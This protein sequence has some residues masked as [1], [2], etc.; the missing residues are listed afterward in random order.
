VHAKLLT[1]GLLPLSATLASDSIF[2]AF[3]SDDK[4]DALLHGHSYTAHAVGCQVALE[5]LKQMKMMV[6]NGEQ[7]WMRDIPPVS[8]AV[9]PWSMWPSEFVNWVSRQTDRVEGVWA[10]GCVLAI[11]MK[12]GDGAGYKSTAA[13]EL[14]ARLAQGDGDGDSRWNVHS[15]VLGNVFYLMGSLKT[16]V[17]D[18]AMLEDMIRRAL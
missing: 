14:K 15:R 7:Q 6:S 16:Q 18:V 1:G 11:H 3:K 5:S 17:E 2:E 10:L 8:S 13:A 12:S 4:S 9:G